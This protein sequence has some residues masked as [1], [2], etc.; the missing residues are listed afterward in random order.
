MCRGLILYLAGCAAIDTNC[1]SKQLLGEFVPTSGRT[2]AWIGLANAD[3]RRQLVAAVVR[4]LPYIYLEFC[5][6][7]GTDRRV[8]AVL[9]GNDVLPA[10]P[11]G[12]AA[13]GSPSGV[14]AD[15]E[16]FWADL[17]Q[18]LRD[19]YSGQIAWALPYPQGL[20]NL[21]DWINKLI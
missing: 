4:A 1:P 16:V 11:G 10:L 6:P 15:A 20:N 12:L 18:E 5:R 2:A 21:P 9:G 13:D 8:Y 14:P 19:R 7:C 17:L 3:Q